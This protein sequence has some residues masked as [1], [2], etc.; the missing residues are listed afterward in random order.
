MSTPLDEAEPSFYEIP[1]AEL[2]TADPFEEVDAEVSAEAPEPSSP[3]SP[4]PAGAGLLSDLPELVSDT[5]DVLPTQAVPGPS[6]LERTDPTLS[7]A[8]V[9]K[10]PEP[11]SALMAWRSQVLGR[12]SVLVST[13]VI[14]VSLFILAG[15]VLIY[16]NDGKLT[17]LWN[18]RPVEAVATTFRTQDLS[19]GL[20]DTRAGRPIFYVRGVV[21]NRG[22]A[23]ARVRVRV[24]LLEGEQLVSA[25]ETV[26]GPEVTPEELFSLASASELEALQSRLEKKAK[27]LAP[28]QTASFVIPFYEF[29]SDLSAYRLRV[30]ARDAD[31][32]AA[33]LASP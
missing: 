26:A 18:P 28:G 13:A 33:A 30:T 19:N 29:P 12:P 8:D 5:M 2:P 20:Y 22:S 24:E 4:G 31:E 23:P 17:G 1:S 32:R 10:E 21:E 14:A 9:P 27:P 7:A 16:R 25:E 11:P 15:T 3:P 6:P